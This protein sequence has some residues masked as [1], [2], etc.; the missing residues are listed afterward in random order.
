[1]EPRLTRIVADAA[2]LADRLGPDW[3]P[4]G[5]DGARLD[6][7][8]DRAAHGDDAGFAERLRWLGT[9]PEA[10]AE[11][12]GE[13]GL[14]E[15]PAWAA[16]F[17]DAMEAMEAD[18]LE[19]AHLPFQ[20]VL[21]GFVSAAKS[22]LTPDFAAALAPQAQA[23]MVE[24][25]VNTLST[26]AAPALQVEF[27]PV[28][29][30]T[31]GKGSDA[32]NFFV[33][34]MRAGGVWA[35][36]EEYAA[37]ARLLSI[38]VTHW[39][40]HVGALAADF[41]ADREAIAETFGGEPPERIAGIEPSLS[42]SHNHGRTVA[43][44]EL[45]TGMGLAY[46]PR[47]VGIEAG[48]FALLAALHGTAGEFRSLKVLERGTRGWVEL[49]RHRPCSD[50]AEAAAYYERSGNLLALLYALE[51]SDCFHEN[52]VA[53]GGYPVL[54]DM[55]TLMHHVVRPPASTVA[56][57][58]AAADDLLF[59]SVL[60][61]GLLPTWESGRGG[62]VVDIS[63]LGA[64]ARQV[65]PYLRRRWTGIG[66]DRQELHHEAIVVE[67]AHHLPFLDGEALRPAPYAEQ[68]V[69]GF[70]RTYAALIERRDELLAPGG[71]LAALGHETLRLVF[72]PTRLY[73]LMLKRLGT[74]KAMRRGVDRSI[75]FDV[76]ARF[77]LNSEAK[78][79]YRALL[80]AELAALERSD[81]PYF[82]LRA[83][84]ADL[85]VPGAAPIADAFSQTAMDRAAARLA[86]FGPDD[87][88]LQ[89][90]FIRASL[91]LSA[92]TAHAPVPAETATVATATATPADFLGAVRRIGDDLAARAIRAEGSVTWIAPQLLANSNRYE[93]RP[94]RLDLY[95]GQAGVALFLAA[96]AGVTGEGRDLALAALAPLRRGALPA[97]AE[98]LLQSGHTIGGVTGIGSIAYA[99]ATCA[100]LLGEP[101]LLD[102]ARSAAA[103]LTPQLIAADQEHDLM[104]GASGA[105][106]AALALGDL[107][108]AKRC[109]EHLLAR[110]LPEGGWHSGRHP[111][112]T[113]LSHG[114]AGIAL[115]LRRLAVATG[116]TRF[117][118]AAEAAL[119]WESAAFD[120]AEA[121]WRDLRHGPGAPASFMN[122]W[123]HGALGIG[124]TRL[125]ALPLHDSARDRA[126]IAAAVA[127]NRGDWLN[128]KDGL[129]CGT[130]A[131]AELL[132]LAGDAPAAASI[133]A[134]VL[135]RAASRGGFALSGNPGVEFFD[136]SFFQGLAGIGYQFL[137]LSAPEKVP[138]VLIYA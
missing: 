133:A 131:R 102:D 128:A 101:A 84:A 68:V 75:E 77:Y 69:A 136:P 103:L 137:R 115:A 87:L 14:A 43:L 45:S 10:A 96:L 35:F 1:M 18:H 7:W 67:S 122:S 120:P 25:L 113:G 83:D 124:L 49:A 66:T 20:P 55:E 138:S 26:L 44:V 57:A 38:A 9:T 117:G 97:S 109:G 16:V 48:W 31:P 54:I 78:R 90:E 46:K 8:R 47:S 53:E 65:T 24:D 86:R 72:H 17:T 93:L 112:T 119:A 81:I 121:N 36:F 60:R 56:A 89:T 40:A 58:E 3:R 15:P 80:A 134:R 52:I 39:V 70:R 114:A 19:G 71:L 79:P 108:T 135:D 42:D 127:A 85:P 94:L 126:D 107:D 37:L 95:G 11:R 88:A 82:T 61:A 6:R 32:Y 132:L 98:A 111:P 118:A 76:M 34:D 51:A 105:L 12:L 59:D 63:G 28:R 116:D 99:L 73:G 62:V 64:E 100:G 104:A 74:P 29:G 30:E 22:R 21:A 2:T 130:M 50:A 41:L 129:C 5:G 4:A 106:L 33:A 110:Q 123:C 125:A 91:A 92:T 23:T 27:A 13:G